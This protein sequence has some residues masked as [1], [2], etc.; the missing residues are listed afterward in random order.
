[1][2]VTSF[3]CNNRFSRKL[4]PTLS[5]CIYWITSKGKSDTNS[6]ETEE[7]IYLH[8][9]L[10]KYFKTERVSIDMIGS[11]LDEVFDAFGI[12]SWKKSKSNQSLDDW[13]IVT[14]SRGFFDRI[15]AYSVSFP[16]A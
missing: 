14:F 9:N 6:G 7:S 16:R 3:S 11:E 1:M 5:K 12:K 15:M 10:L 8:Y 2:V 4:A 13:T